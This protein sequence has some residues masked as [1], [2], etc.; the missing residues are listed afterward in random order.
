MRLLIA[1]LISG[2]FVVGRENASGD[3]EE[4]LQVMFGSGLVVNLVPMFSPFS[5]ALVTILKELVISA[6]EADSNM[7]VF[8][9]DRLLSRNLV[10]K[11]GYVLA[12]GSVKEN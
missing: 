6:V 9:Q 2:E 5:D 4:C 7:Q 12:R 3:L 1:K 10:L 11:E 8:Y